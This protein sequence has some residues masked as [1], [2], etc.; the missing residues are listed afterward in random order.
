MLV[1]KTILMAKKETETKWKTP[2]MN[3]TVS[4]LYK[5]DR[6]SRNNN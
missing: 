2:Y 4:P 6:L 3:V 1:G 5:P